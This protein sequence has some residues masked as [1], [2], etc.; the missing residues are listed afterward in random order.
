MSIK[1]IIE[2]QAKAGKREDVLKALEA[3]HESRLGFPGF[4]GFARYEVIDNPDSIIE[5]AEWESAEA[6]QKWLEASLESGVMNRLIETLG[7]PFKAITVR[8]VE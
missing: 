3:V 1:A 6:R 2:L 8:Q 7:V 4:I 5:I